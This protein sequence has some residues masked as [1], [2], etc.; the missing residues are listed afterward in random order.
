L[1]QGESPGQEIAEKVH[2]GEPFTRVQL[3]V[4]QG[5]LSLQTR[6]PC[7]VHCPVVGSQRFSPHCEDGKG[8]QT[9]AFVALQTQTPFTLIGVTVAHLFGG[10]MTGVITQVPFKQTFGLQGSVDTQFEQ[11]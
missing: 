9:K 3:S 1:E 6:P 7:G 4:V 11:V 2:T 8:G 10:Q 5:S